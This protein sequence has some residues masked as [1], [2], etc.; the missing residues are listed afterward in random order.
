MDPYFSQNKEQIPHPSY[1][2]YPY[3]VPN[4]PD[5]SAQSASYTPWPY[6]F[7]PTHSNGYSYPPGYYGPRPPFPYELPPT[8]FPNYYHPYFT[9]MPNYPAQYPQIDQTK[10]QTHCCGCPN[11]VC[12]G[13]HSPKVK[14]DEEK[15]DVDQRKIPNS[16]YPYFWF[17][18]RNNVQQDE[19]EKQKKEKREAQFP[20]PIVWMPEDEVKEKEKKD[21]QI[22]WPLIWMPEDDAKETKHQHANK[23]V[24]EEAAKPSF[25]IIPL[26]FLEHGDKDQTEMPKFPVVEKKQGGEEAGKERRDCGDKDQAEVKRIPVMDQAEVKRIPVMEKKEGSEKVGKEQPVKES[27]REKMMEKK[28]S[29]LPPVCLRVDPP[30]HKKPTNGSSKEDKNK[31]EV[32]VVDV[33]GAKDERKEREIEVNKDLQEERKIDDVRRVS[34]PKEDKIKKEIKVVDVRGAEGKELK[35]RDIQGEDLKEKLEERNVVGVKKSKISEQDAAVLTQ[36]VY[37]G[38]NVRRWDPLEKLKKIRGV[39]EKAQELM[40]RL[41]HVEESAIQLE[42]KEL[43]VLSETIMNLLLQLDTIQVCILTM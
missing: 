43:L 35:E 3:P 12:N 25:R 42:K 41:K 31:K 5:P 18:P 19:I 8:N 28:L 23:Q 16:A 20:W 22:P 40:G 39:H 27:T 13:T 30:R 2:F 26:K 9:P 6:Q 32:K 15:H 33:K 10:S 24:S 1:P 7:N 36:S 4:R 11:H 14:I 38:Y 29:K 21:T 34:M 37:R 17:S